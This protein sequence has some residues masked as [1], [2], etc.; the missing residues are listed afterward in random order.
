M[1]AYPVETHMRVAKVLPLGDDTRE[2]QRL[3]IANS[4]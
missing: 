3:T 2:V 1:E 4:R